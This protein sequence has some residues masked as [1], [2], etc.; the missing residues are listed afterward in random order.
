[1]IDLRKRK[2]ISPVI[3]TVVL[4]A[5]TITVVIGVAYWL[6]GISSQYTSFEKVEIRDSSIVIDAYGN[7]IVTLNLKNSGT[8]TATIS[9]IYIND[10][11]ATPDSSAPTAA[12]STLTSDLTISTP[13]QLTS[14]Q[15]GD[16][17]IWVGTNYGT[18]SSGTTVNIKVHS[19]A[20]MDYIKLIT[21]P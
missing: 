18:L 15:D 3:A 7:W 2:G 13:W 6:G 9:S 10:I 12:V 21:L 17:I 4:V 11:A 8:A 14:G 20:G 5:V 1:M 19:A 16:L